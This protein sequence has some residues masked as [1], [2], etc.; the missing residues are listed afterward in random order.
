LV[1]QRPVA[2]A[3]R[4][5]SGLAS[6][7]VGDVDHLAGLSIEVSQSFEAGEIARLQ[8][9]EFRESGPF[10]LAIALARSEPGDRPLDF[11]P[12]ETCGRQIGGSVHQLIG[13]PGGLSQTPSQYSTSPRPGQR[14]ASRARRAP[15]APIRRAANSR[16]AS[17]SSD[18][19]RRA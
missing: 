16:P 2:F 6:P 8:G 7:P 5:E 10:R 17:R 9:D 18:R 3:R 12:G 19:K 4:F 11:G 15:A 1:D 13:P 14:F